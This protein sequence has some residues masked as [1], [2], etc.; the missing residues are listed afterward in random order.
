MINTYK[1][2]GE[3]HI[4]NWID[5]YIASLPTLKVLDPQWAIFNEGRAW[6]LGYDQIGVEF[7]DE[8]FQHQISDDWYIIRDYCIGFD[9]LDREGWLKSAIAEYLPD[10]SIGYDFEWLDWVVNDFN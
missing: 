4:I 7:M 1:A 6:D 3:Q 2:I 5:K 8:N 9:D 10:D